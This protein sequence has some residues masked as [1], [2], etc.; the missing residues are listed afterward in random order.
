M[1]QF[2]LSSEGKPF[3]YSLEP[4]LEVAV[5]HKKP[6]KVISKFKSFTKFPYCFPIKNFI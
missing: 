1:P 6:A 2:F 3:S 4:A 5:I